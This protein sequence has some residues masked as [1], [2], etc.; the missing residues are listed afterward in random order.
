MV[1][2][3][4][5]TN[6]FLHKIEDLF[7]ESDYVLRYEKGNFKPGYCIL[8][9]TKIAVVNKYH[10]LEGKINCLIEILRTID[11]DWKTL[12]EKNQLLYLDLSQTELEL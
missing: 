8:K 7:A 2:E 11:M 4:K 3:V 1:S 6:H 10:S 9:D 5:Y 12:G